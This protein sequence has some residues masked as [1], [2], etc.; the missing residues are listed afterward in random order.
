M[1]FRDERYVRLY[2]RD[3]LTWKLL[4][5]E[6]RAVLMFL[7]RKLDRCGVLDIGNIEPCDAVA[8]VIDAPI[9]FVR[10]GFPRCLER[11]VFELGEGTIVMPQFLDA[12]EAE[13]TP[14]KRTREWRAR[15]RDQARAVKRDETSPHSVT[16][17]HQNGR[18]P[19]V[20]VTPS[21]A[22]PNRTEPIPIRRT[23]LELPTGNETT[24]GDERAGATTNGG[25]APPP[26][27][28][29]FLEALGKTVHLRALADPRYGDYWR[30]IY[31]T[32]DRNDLYFVEE[33]GRADLWLI[34][35]PRRQKRNLRQ[36]FLNWI[37]RCVGDLEALAAAPA[38]QLQL[39]RTRRM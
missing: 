36:Y 26:I 8:A 28:P 22:V 7:M 2:T 16:K 10:I 21:R 25:A 29:D 38:A 5:F 13:Q 17:R 1:D 6:G 12:Q 31:E 11:G 35:N 24:E 23:I 18:S 39:H 4:G 34:A 30:T 37:K 9:E 19:G 15:R 32:Y 27:D 14:A 33:I 3:T 20:M